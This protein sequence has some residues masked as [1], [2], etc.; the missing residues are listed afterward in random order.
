MGRRRRPGTSWG[1]EGF[2]ARA[3]GTCV[4]GAQL[5]PRVTSHRPQAQVSPGVP[6]KRFLESLWVFVMVGMSAELCV[7]VIS[8]WAWAHKPR[9]LKWRQVGQTLVAVPGEACMKA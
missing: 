9:C 3:V 1:K 2:P 5:P 4:G 7:C 8:W 6:R